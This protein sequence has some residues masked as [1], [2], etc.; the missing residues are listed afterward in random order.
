M[1]IGIMTFWW[2]NDNY[3]QLLQCYALQKFL[4]KKG[5]DVFT[6]KYDPIKDSQTPMRF[7]LLK[8]FN[9]K[10][11]IHVIKMQI[12]KR[13]IQKEQL[14]HDRGFSYFREKYLCFSEKTYY[15]YRDLEL[16]PPKADIYIVG[17]DQVWNFTLRD[18]HTVRNLI[19]AYMLDFGEDTTKKLSYAAS[20][21][22]SRNKKNI[23]NE[24][25]PLLKRFSYVSVREQSGIRLCEEC[26][27][28]NVDWTPD[29]TMLLEAEDYRKLYRI[30]CNKIKD[31]P[32]L[33]LYM[34]N[35]TCDFDIDNVYKFAKGKGLNVIYV[36]GNGVVDNK[37]KEYASIPE[38]LW[39][40]D[41]AEFIITNS[42][43][44]A[45]FSTLFNK[46]YGVIRLTGKFTGM[47]KRLESLFSRFDIKERYITNNDFS[48][49][50]TFYN[51][52]TIGLPMNFIN[53]L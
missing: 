32:F 22:T 45:V 39:L 14:S 31:K 44:C 40:I 28:S 46:Q 36:T 33:F 49:L 42:F 35:N 38:W 16:Q 19:H 52:K 29:P 10:K 48:V 41:N 50:E 17:S 51:P 7:K 37:E 5:H 9:I 2:S 24:V 4:I 6:I 25:S 18:F 20:W 3:G 47:N 23:I 8:V 1:K 26:G 27:V 13:K 15:N 21:G 12:N 30:E 11:V 53:N 34:L 43:H